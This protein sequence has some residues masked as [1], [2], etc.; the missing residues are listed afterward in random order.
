VSRYTVDDHIKSICEKAGVRGRREL[1][2]LVFVED[3]L[4][5]LAAR[6]PVDSGG[7]FVRAPEA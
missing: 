1:I 3:H 4:P 5:Q 7:R 2:G 6:T